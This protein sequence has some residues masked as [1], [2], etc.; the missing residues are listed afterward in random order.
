[1]L[2]NLKETTRGLTCPLLA[3]ITLLLCIGI[4]SCASTDKVRALTEKTDETNLLAIELKRDQARMRAELEILQKKVDE[5]SNSVIRTDASSTQELKELRARL[6]E[7]L[8][9][10][11]DLS[12]RQ[13]ALRAALLDIE[14]IINS[15]ANKGGKKNQSRKRIFAAARQDYDSG[16]YDSAVM[17]FRNYVASYPDSSAADNAQYL[18][19]ESLFAA[20]KFKE[21]TEEFQRVLDKYPRSDRTAETLLRLGMC[22]I[23]LKNA[24]KAR[25]PLEQLIERFPDSEEA[26]LARA[27]LDKLG[28]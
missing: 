8:M 15:K 22:Q 4:I 21:A 9:S 12:Q 3:V 23:E 6:D 26:R 28:E 19:G 25:R 20:K 16:A 13:E 24:T 14:D 27:K 7:M 17:G 1:M 2:N 10:L 11:E 18:I 5:L